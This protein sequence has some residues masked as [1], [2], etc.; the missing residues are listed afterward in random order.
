MVGKSEVAVLGITSERLAVAS[1]FSKMLED[2][3][4]PLSPILGFDRTMRPTSFKVPG[5]DRLR[6]DLLVPTSGRE[7]KVFPVPELDAHATA[8]PHLDYL[9]GEPLDAVVLGRDSVVPVKVPR[10]ER[11][12]LH[13]LLVSQLRTSTSDKRNKDVDQAAILVAALSEGDEGALDDAMDAF[14]KGALKKL[15]R[16]GAVAA[17]VLAAHERAA[18]VLER[19]LA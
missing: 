16:A 4:V 6:V 19:L 7:V 2:S 18:N 11:F 9:L 15:R 1:S 8:L 13:K 5:R 3:T 14:P 10:P 17:R 12:A